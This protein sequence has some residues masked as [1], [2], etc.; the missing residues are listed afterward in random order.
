MLTEK[1]ACGPPFCVRPPGLVALPGATAGNA[2]WHDNRQATQ[3]TAGIA[4]E[5]ARGHTAGPLFSNKG[6]TMKK[7]LL[8]AA[9]AATSAALP[10]YAATDAECQAMWTKADV[11]KDGVLSDAEAM[12]YAAAM[13]VHE[14]S[15]GRRQDRPGGLHRCLQGRRLRA[16]PGRC[17][18]AAQGRQQL[19]RRPGQGSRHGARRDRRRPSSRRTMTASGAAP[20]RR[21]A[22]RPGRRRL[23]GQR[24]FPARA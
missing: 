12:R 24:R 19:H 15:A 16:R 3:P 11:N 21:T 1:A 4:V 13:R 7:L 17:R 18:R 6:E 9:L 22:S 10:A 2:R 20:P 14:R 23:Q 8:V 5:C